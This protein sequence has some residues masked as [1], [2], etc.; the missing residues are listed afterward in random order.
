MATSLTSPAL[1][2]ATDKAIIAARKAL[3]KVGFFATDFSAEAV[4]PGTTMKIPIFTPGEATAFNASSNNYENAEGSVTWVPVTFD[5]HVKNT[6]QFDD[7]DFLLANGTHFW[8]N[9]GRASGDAIAKSI[10]AA[11][12]K[13][14]NKTNIPKTAANEVVWTSA[15]KTKV[16][17]LRAVCDAADI[18]PAQT[19]LML[20]P[21][22]FAELLSTLD[23]NIYGGPSAIR[24][25]IVEGLYGFKAV[26]E[27]GAL[28]SGATEKLNGALIPTDGMAVAGRL[29]PVLSPSVYE[30]VGNTR[31]EVSGLVVG[32]RRHGNPATGANYVTHEALFGAALAQPGKCVR[33]V[34]AATA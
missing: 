24:D 9:A 22:R 26:I 6:F 18:D 12:S 2:Y 19:V 14:I 17:D 29:V 25:G 13:L 30:E 16:P 28:D 10:I 3:A 31:D 15:A 33:L 1:V 4:Q 27:N 20:T 34:S 5:H 32:V 7:K 11:V 23:A 8:A 21:T